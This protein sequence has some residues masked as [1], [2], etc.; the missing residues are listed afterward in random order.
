MSPEEQCF[1]LWCNLLQ[2]IYDS[3]L[4]YYRDG[5]GLG[6]LCLY[7]QEFRFTLSLSVIMNCRTITKVNMRELDHN[8]G[9]KS[10]SP[11]FLPFCSCSSNLKHSISKTVRS[12]ALNLCTQVGFD[13]PTCSDLSKCL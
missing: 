4:I 10:I 12:T 7:I 13:D 3:T 1:E 9:K 5:R 2:S 11:I 6:P 8:H